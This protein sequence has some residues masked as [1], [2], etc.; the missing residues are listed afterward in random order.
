MKKTILMC[1]AVLGLGAGS[2]QASLI[3]AADVGQSGTI[4]FNGN[5]N[6]NNVPGLT[7]A[8]TFT[9]TSYND[10]T[11]QLVFGVSVDNTSSGA[12]SSRISGFGF[13]TNP[14][15]TGGLSTS[16][17]FTNVLTS[18]NLPN[19][20]GNIDVCVTANNCTG[21]GGN[22]VLPADPAHNFVLTLNF[23]DV[24]A[25]GVDFSN[26][27]IRYQSISGTTFGNS[28]TGRGT[29]GGGTLFD[30]PPPVP[31][32]TSMVLLGLGMIGAGIARRRK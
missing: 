6:G 12:I 20:V 30:V 13:D 31:E 5:V 28:G 14:E 23:T 1:A 8:I 21:G 19:G 32:P 3:T 11:N 18:E 4:L 22:G 16:T 10:V 9:L 17:I 27:V 26:F 25:A 15:V 29:P 2:A 7:A 24:T